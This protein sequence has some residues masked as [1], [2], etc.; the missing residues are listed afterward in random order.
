MTPRETIYTVQYYHPQT[1][2]G[3]DLK[4]FQTQEQSN[5]FY[6]LLI[7]NGYQ[8]K[9]TDNQSTWERETPNFSNYKFVTVKVTA[10]GPVCEWHKIKTKF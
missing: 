4:T 2:N 8:A 7:A 6:A 10:A 3:I 9:E 1:T 5:K